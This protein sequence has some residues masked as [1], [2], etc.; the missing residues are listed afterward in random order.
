MFFYC[1]PIC[2]Q[3]RLQTTDQLAYLL[4][5]GRNNIETDTVFLVRVFLKFA[6]SQKFRVMLKIVTN[7]GVLKKQKSVKLKFSCHTASFSRRTVLKKIGLHIH[8]SKKKTLVHESFVWRFIQH[9][10]CFIQNNHP[11]IFV[12]VVISHTSTDRILFFFKSYCVS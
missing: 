8:V 10:E 2:K 12:I 3:Q 4:L 1:Y 9:Y 5:V 11:H 6:S 7:I